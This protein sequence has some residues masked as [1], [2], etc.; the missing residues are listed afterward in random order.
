MVVPEEATRRLS[1]WRGRPQRYEELESA[2]QALAMDYPG[3][4]ER[5]EIGRSR[6]DRPIWAVRIGGRTSVLR[7]GVEATPAALVAP[8]FG[9]DPLAGASLTLTLLRRL[10][11][12]GSNWEGGSHLNDAALWVV[13]APEP[14][15][16]FQAPPPIPRHLDRNFPIRWDPW[17]EDGTSPGPY[18][19]SEPES[20]ALASFVLG[21]PGISVAVLLSG[22]QRGAGG[23]RP[24]VRPAHG[25][26]LAAFLEEGL[27]IRVLD[28]RNP[29][30]QG[31]ARG[32]EFDAWRFSRIVLRELPQLRFRELGVERV[33]RSLFQLDLAIGNGGAVSTA[34]GRL[35]PTWGRVQ[36]AL[37]G[38][39][40]LSV[41]VASG[42]PVAEEPARRP[43]S[44]PNAPTNFD[45]VEVDARTGQ[46]SLAPLAPG[47]WTWLR[48]WV[49]AEA[50]GR[51]RATAR[52]PRAARAEA[53]VEL[54]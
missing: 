51:L 50:G 47:E 36:L 54:R 18:P 24:Y 4:C 52:T 19:L 48:L 8:A 26:S 32:P 33:D 38:G 16:W 27:S 13:P 25:G 9:A 6:A 34:V 11:A 45:L 21:H 17:G 49:R 35:A 20:R 12:L 28:D 31:C 10:A 40:L 30:F 44:E 46:V 7:N 2:L 23:A 5:V 53:S 43:S 14:D 3:L 42:A 15:A 22:P 37:D 29:L 1:P 39:H 41:G